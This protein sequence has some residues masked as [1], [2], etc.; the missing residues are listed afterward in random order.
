MTKIV[1]VKCQTDFRTALGEIVV[2]VVEMAHNPP[3]PYRIWMADVLRC[4]GC[5]VE[6]VG[7]WADRPLARDGEAAAK[8][9]DIQFVGKARII[10]HYERAQA[11]GKEAAK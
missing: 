8:L 1:C 2:I 7:A 9:A 10:Y 6:V 11:T 5:G 3:V 4:P